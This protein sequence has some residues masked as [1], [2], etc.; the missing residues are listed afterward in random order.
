MTDETTQKSRRAGAS[1]AMQTGIRLA[2][3]SLIVG[4]AL[5]ILRIDPI[6][7]WK[8]AWHWLNQGVVELFGSGMEGLSLIATLIVTGAIIVVPIWLVRS[9]LSGRK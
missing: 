7:L 8:G 6:R 2:I 1:S 4:A 3:I 5:T 9:L